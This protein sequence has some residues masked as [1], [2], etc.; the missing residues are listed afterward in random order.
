MFQNL[1][2]ARKKQVEPPVRVA[3]LDKIATRKLTFVLHGREHIITPPD[4][5]NWLE[6][7]EAN[8]H[9]MM[10]ADK[11]N[12]TATD[13]ID[14]YYNLVHRLCPSITKEDI[15]NSTQMQV[16]SLWQLVLDMMNGFSQK[17]TM[18]NIAM[19]GMTKKDIN[20]LIQILSQYRST[21]QDSLP[22]SSENLAGPSM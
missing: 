6:I 12:L 7:V 22:N 4:I 19:Q 1:M 11:E 3:D 15:S 16:A 2:P 9:L 5:K 10:L 20:N 17:K 18:A 13:L 8:N 14:G 21:L